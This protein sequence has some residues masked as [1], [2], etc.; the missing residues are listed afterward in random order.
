[1]RREHAVWNQHIATQAH[2]NT[3]E[4]HRS[5]LEYSRTYFRL[6]KQVLTLQSHLGILQQHYQQWDHLLKTLQSDPQAV[7]RSL[8]VRQSSLTG[9]VVI[10]PL[11]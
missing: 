7:S 3:V 6:E 2:Q 4:L 8:M 11:P 9:L 5:F 10:T 1:L